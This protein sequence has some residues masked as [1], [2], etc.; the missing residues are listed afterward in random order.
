M[1]TQLRRPP[2]PSGEFMQRA[3]RPAAFRPGRSQVL[4]ARPGAG[5]ESGMVALALAGM[6]LAPLP[7]AW[8]RSNHGGLHRGRAVQFFWEV[9][10]TLFVVMDPASTVPVFLG[11]TRGRSDRDRKRLAWQATIVAF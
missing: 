7:S 1:G 3:V 9:F 11:V 5:K 10:V 8:K 6:L 4:G 2:V